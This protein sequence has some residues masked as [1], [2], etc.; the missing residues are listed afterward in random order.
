MYS[1]SLK[2]ADLVFLWAYS[3]KGWMLQKNALTGGLG[4]MGTK[5][6][7]QGKGGT[8]SVSEKLFGLANR[9]E[10]QGADAQFSSSS[11]SLSLMQRGKKVTYSFGHP[12]KASHRD[13][14]CL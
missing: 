10:C 12:K 13:E 9:L 11:K 4:A 7:L 8:G 2:T 3:D 14:R 1:V 6:Y 5:S